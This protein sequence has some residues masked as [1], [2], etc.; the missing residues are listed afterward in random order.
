V[1][2]PA[3]GT[4]VTR[5]ARFCAQCGA[6]LEPR[7]A[8]RAKVSPASIEAGDRRVVTAVF[9][10][11]VD[12][13]R[14]IAEHDPED[15]RDRV[16]NALRRMAEAIE[17]LDGTREKFIGD[18]VFAVFGWPRAHDDDPV[19][20][21]LAALAIRAALREPDD[22]GEP[23]EVRIGL[24]T[25][26]V[27]AAPRGDGSGDLSVT[28]EAI[29]TAARIQSLA[30]PGEILLDEA[31][32]RGGRDRLSVDDRGSV[33][34]RGQSSSARI[35][36]LTG[37]IGLTPPGSRRATDSPLVGRARETARIRKVLQRVRRSGHGAVV[38]LTGEAGMGKTRL[39]SGLESEAR[40]L[41]YV[42]TWTESVSY[43]R[44]EPYRFGRV[45]AQAVADE[46]GIDSGA[47][48]RRLLFEPGTDPATARRYGAAIAAVAREA[49]FSGWEEEAR[50]IPDD[51]AETAAM[52]VEVAEAYID[53]MM[54]TYG[55]RVIVLD[56][57]HWLDAS[58]AAMVEM[59][60][61]T[62]A[63]RP[64]VVL[65]AMRP[66]P[67]PAWASLPH[68]E[69]LELAGLAPP[70]TAQLATIVARAALDADDARRI[71]ERTQGNPLFI[72]ETVR[73][74]IE[75]GS[76]ELRDGRM[77]LVDAEA[78][79]LPLTLRAVLG[80][81]IDALDPPSRDLLRVAS[82][83][84][85]AFDVAVLQDLLDRPIAPGALERLVDAALIVPADS[86]SWR[87]SHPLVHDAAYAGILA[88]RRRRLHGRLAD[89]LEASPARISAVTIAVHRAA[90]GDAARAIPL[91]DE[92]AVSA[93]ALGAVPEA[94]AFWRTAADLSADSREAAR[95][96]AAADAAL[97]A[98]GG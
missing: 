1:D 2:C 17:R 51:P 8:V 24:A 68:V 28:G 19:R 92:A 14:M 44:G 43:G 89:H 79:R 34:L 73:A 47:F 39:L 76:L 60:V 15:V 61:T 64:L 57:V 10:D 83:V 5:R 98:S 11:L 55:P 97:A 58:S 25:G 3:C 23:L 42:W 72:G 20:A 40:Q 65:A 22:G 86:G 18:A 85:I 12:Y 69:R 63:V 9:A 94:A 4:R 75:D 31:T 59:I 27:V 77:T 53:R 32:V 71:H 84:G 74:F 38:L 21:A 88:S 90:A 6:R 62:A 48:V 16:Q 37:E 36:A 46:H 30:Q 96:R 7:P 41:G 81:R 70:E 93:L 91:L 78:P 45:F 13:V 35:Y 95:Y 87:F 82:V 54:A 66:G 52:L 50:F 26:E 33:I 49:A 56:D 67:E 80:A 29:T